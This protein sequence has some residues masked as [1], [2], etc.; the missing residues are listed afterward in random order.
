MKSEGWGS[1]FPTS[2][3]PSD[4]D[5]SLIPTNE[6]L[7]V[8]APVAGDPVQNRETWGTQNRAD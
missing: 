8:G 2:R 5:L 1:W 4:V 6:D 7:F 3:H